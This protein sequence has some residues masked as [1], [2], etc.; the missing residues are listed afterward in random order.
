MR[1][2]TRS[3]ACL[4]LL[5]LG[6]TSIAPAELHAQSSDRCAISGDKTASPARLRLGEEVEIRLTLKPDCPPESFR[7]VDIVLAIDRS[8][9]M[10]GAKLAAAKSAAKAFVDTTDLTQQRIGVVSFDMNGWIGI[11]L[12]TDADAIK[13]AIDAIPLGPGTNISAA[14]DTAWNDVLALNARPSALPVLILIGDG[15]PNFPQGIDPAVAAVRSA[16]AARLGGAVIYTIGLGSD[17]KPDLLKQVAGGETNYFFSPDESELDIIYRAIALQ[18]GNFAVRDLV[19]VDEL[20]ADVDYVAGSARPAPNEI[21]GKRLTWNAALVPSTGISYSYRVKPKRTGTYAT[22]DRAVANF[23]NADNGDDSFVFPK[24]QITVLDPPAP[25]S[26][27]TGFEWW[28]VMVHSFPDAVGQS[29]GGSPRGCNNSFDSGDWIGGTE[30]P[31]PQL[32]YVLK[33]ADGEV[34][35]QGKG[36]PG[37][38]RVDQR[39]YIRTCQPPPYTL[40]LVTGQLGGYALCPNLSTTVEITKRDF[41]PLSFRRTE[42][43]FG[44]LRGA[45]EFD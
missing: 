8:R 14:I 23:V 41:R 26:A 6:W 1:A 36:L 22:N 44:F 13:Q 18:V 32:E 34:I 4:A 5:A 20:S 33:A 11:G 7:T 17:V 37:P 28:T 38:G 21:L 10:A 27:C 42:L 19:L 30:D 15:D 3:L 39:I 31:L 35:W 29:G 9:S 43:R 25:P 40:S 12:S 45:A 2:L 24:P 16:N